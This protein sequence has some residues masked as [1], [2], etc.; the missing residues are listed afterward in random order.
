MACY[1]LYDILI[2]DSLTIKHFLLFSEKIFSPPIIFLVML[3]ERDYSLDPLTETFHD[4][5]F[6]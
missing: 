5:L 6:K 1:T 2:S 3:A 4:T